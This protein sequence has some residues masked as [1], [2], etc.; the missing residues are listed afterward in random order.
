M[1]K[2]LIALAIASA[3]STVAMA[4]SNVAIYGL[5]D[6]GLA[7]A[8]ADR[9]DGINLK[10]G[11]G[12]L[13]APSR[14]GFTGTEALESDL[15]AGFTLEYGITPNT[16][17]GI[18]TAREQSVNLTSKS[19]GAVKLGYMPTLGKVELDKFDSMRSTAFA[20]LGALKGTTLNTGSR[21]GNTVAYIS[22]VIGSGFTVGGT[23][24][25]DTTLANTAYGNGTKQERIIGALVDYTFGP[26]TVGYAHHKGYDL[27]RVAGTHNAENMVGVKYAVTPDVVLTGSHQTDIYSNR[28]TDKSITSVGAQVA[29]TGKIGVDVGYASLNDK[30]V[31]NADATAWGVQSNY[32]LSK[33][34]ALYAGYTRVDNK[35]GGTNVAF[36]TTNGVAPLGTGSMASSG[37]GAGVKHSF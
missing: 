16:N 32:N 29:V 28:T 5:V 12:S 6:M 17:T 25:T 27:N 13:Y 18:G 37:I 26:L 9:A 33:R 10:N 4:Q 7:S 35:N 30:T 3:T 24:S 8:K 20:P 19:L 14:L 1:K 23:Y 15:S 36:G 11:V 34:T 2:S 21:A 22:P 31:A